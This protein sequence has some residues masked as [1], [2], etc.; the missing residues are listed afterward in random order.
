MTELE[1][2]TM[3]VDSVRAYYGTERGTAKHKEILDYY[4]S[5][6]N[7]PRGYKMTVNDPWCATTPSA[8][9]IKLGLEKIIYSECSCTK[10]I[11]LYKAAGRWVEDDSY[12]PQPGDLIMYDWDDNGVGD[13]AG[14]PDHVG[15]VV[16]ITGDT[17][18]VIEGNMG[19]P[20]RVWHRDIKIGGRYIRG[21]CCPDYASMSDKEDDNMSKFGDVQDG[22]W[23]ADSVKRAQELGLMVGVSEDKF[24]VGEPVTREQLAAVVVRL[25]DKFSK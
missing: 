11:E 8:I 24:G 15:V 22:S 5:N 17:I 1:L 3:F 12:T 19:S 23:Y 7:L 14:E 6:P 10:M 2:R 9:A 25:F 18:R 4:N 16:R 21:Y 13:N 20:S